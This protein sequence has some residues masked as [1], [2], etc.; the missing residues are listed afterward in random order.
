[1]KIFAGLGNP[2]DKYA[3][4]RHN[5]GFMAVDRIA[6]DHGFG[7]WR[8]KFQAL[9]SEG[10]LG[11][12]KIILLKP[13]TFMNLSGQSVGEAL[14]F[15]KLESTDLT[16]FHDEIDLA[17]GK[18]R[19]KAGGGHAGHNGLRS[20]HSHIGPHYDRVRLGVGHP[21]HKDAVPGYVLRDFAKVE[22]E[23]LDDLMRGISDGAAFL[24]DGDG[25]K[26]LNAVALRMNPARSGTGKAHSTGANPAPKTT[27]PPKAEDTPKADVSSEE[28]SRSPLQ[29]L[30]DRFR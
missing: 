28:D 12:E 4:N 25:A 6:E 24:A 17:P 26:F 21:G 15:Y 16:V 8:Q 11:S 2:G 14:K 30:V 3:G 23:W 9:V 19:L 1:M 18:I 13:Q 10:R 20:I 27:A 7:P 29:K 5:I 22:Q